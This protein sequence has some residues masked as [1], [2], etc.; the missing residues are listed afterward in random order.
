MFH[1]SK[2]M[3]DPDYEATSTLPNDYFLPQL[4]MYLHSKDM[5]DSDYVTTSTLSL[6]LVIIANPSLKTNTKKIF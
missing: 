1:H 6:F 5:E 3:E 2:D 4:H